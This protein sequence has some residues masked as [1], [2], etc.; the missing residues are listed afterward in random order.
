[1]KQKR[2]FTLIELLAVI[3][4]LGVL[5]TIAVTS[6]INISIKLKEKMYCEKIAFIENGAKQYGSDIIDS[7]D[8]TGIT[9]TVG[10]LV[11]KGVLKKDVDTPGSYIQ[12]P[13]SKVSMDGIRVRI[14]LKNHRAY[15]HV[16]ADVSKCEA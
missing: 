1:M 15:A 14:Y 3:A 16:D 7:L 13:R 9:L 4:L 6:A 10:D 12:D 8:A 2:G 5:A 11:N